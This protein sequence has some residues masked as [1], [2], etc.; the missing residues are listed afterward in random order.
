MY[1]SIREH[2]KH[3]LRTTQWPL[4][5]E[6]VLFSLSMQD[7]RFITM[8]RLR[9]K[10]FT[11]AVFVHETSFNSSAGHSE[12]SFMQHFA[13]LHFQN[14]TEL[15]K[16]SRL[17][18]TYIKVILDSNCLNSIGI[19]RLLDLVHLPHMLYKSNAQCERAP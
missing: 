7:Y 8:S 2:F 14:E 17:T 10:F 16:F 5:G 6:H 12:N 1:Y 9:G 18:W 15:T 11:S 3:T 13:N 19:L 4:S